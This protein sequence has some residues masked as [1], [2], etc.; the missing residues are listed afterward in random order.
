MAPTT[1]LGQ[2]TTTTP[3]GRDQSTGYPMHV[4][5][6]LASIRGVAYAARGAVNSPANY[7]RTKKYLRAAFQKQMDGIGFSFVEI[8]SA[9]PADWHLTPQE[10]LKWIEEKLIPE[11]PLGEF[12]N[13]DTLD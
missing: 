5:E 12:K 10:S 6:L 1:L 13:V 9:C 7:Q 4:P 8:L 11:Y 2:R 3:E